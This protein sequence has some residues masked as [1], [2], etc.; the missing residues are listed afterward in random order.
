MNLI[1]ICSYPTWEEIVRG[2]INGNRVEDVEPN[3]ILT[4][5]EL[6]TLNEWGSTCKKLFDA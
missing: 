1:A 2:G 5:T 3:G 4:A 6:K